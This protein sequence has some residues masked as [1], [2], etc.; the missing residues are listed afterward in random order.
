MKRFLP[1]FNS[2]TSG[3]CSWLLPVLALAAIINYSLACSSAPKQQEEITEKQNKAAGFAESGNTYYTQGMY[4]RALE[5]FNLALAYNGA[6]YNEPGIAQSFNSIGKVYLAQGY[7]ETA[8]RYYQKAYDMALKLNNQ[9]FILAQSLNNLGELGLARADYANALKQFT[10]AYELIGKAEN[11]PSPDGS[12]DAKKIAAYRAE[13]TCTKA[14]ILHNLGSSYKQLKE[15]DKAFDYLNQ[16]LTINLAHKKYMEV[17]ANYY[18][19]AS[20]YS[21]KGEYDRAQAHIQSALEYD[22]KV[23][24]SLGIA[25]DYMALGLIHNKLAQ[26]EEAYNYFQRSLFVYRSLATIYP[27]LALEV[28]VKNLYTQLIKAADKLGKKDEA[29]EYRQVLVGKKE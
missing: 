28:E 24:N 10:Q 25:K 3:S 20:L 16:A 12:K 1:S 27:N 6:I 22:T 7:P 18:M 2:S 5:F 8:T 15:A 13:V 17:A 29:D 14:V 4:E 19:L 11:E 23:E 26:T 9:S 21:E